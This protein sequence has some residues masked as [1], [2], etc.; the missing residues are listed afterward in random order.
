MFGAFE[1]DIGRRC[2]MIRPDLFR[3]RITDV[4]YCISFLLID[5]D[6]ELKPG[7]VLFNLPYKVFTYI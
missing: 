3:I 2:L 5:K 7:S 4:F 1:N 6:N